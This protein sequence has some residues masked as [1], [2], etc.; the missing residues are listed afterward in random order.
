MKR[1]RLRMFDNTV[2]TKIFWPN[3]EEVTGDWRLHN[4]GLDYLGCSLD[5][6]QVTKSRRMIL[7]EHVACMEEKCIQAFG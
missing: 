3:V 6:I 2:L 7:V 1:Y 5:I 4:K